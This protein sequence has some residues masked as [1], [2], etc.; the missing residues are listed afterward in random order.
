MGLLKSILKKPQ[1][2]PI[3]GFI[4]FLNFVR[5]HGSGM[6]SIYGSNHFYTGTY[7]G[8]Y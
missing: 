4:L 6:E 7:T 1:Q 2:P 3:H 5:R 8:T